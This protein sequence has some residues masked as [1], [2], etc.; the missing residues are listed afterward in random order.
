VIVSLKRDAPEL[1]SYRI[2]DGAIEEEPVELATGSG[3]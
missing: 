3:A 2:V 1:R